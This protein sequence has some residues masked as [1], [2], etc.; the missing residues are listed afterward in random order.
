MI[1][2][3]REDGNVTKESTYVFYLKDSQVYFLTIPEL[4]EIIH[5]SLEKAHL[6]DSRSFLGFNV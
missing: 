5:F 4:L 1:K 6:L 3:I 2:L